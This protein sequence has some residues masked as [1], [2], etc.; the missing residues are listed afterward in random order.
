MSESC[1]ELF[2]FFAIEM[3]R[4]SFGPP[5]DSLGKV[6]ALIKAGLIDL[7]FLTGSPVVF[8]QHEPLDQREELILSN[9]QSQIQIDCLVNAVL[10]GPSYATEDSLLYNLLQRQYLSPFRNTGGIAVNQQVQ[11]LDANEQPVAGL[12]IIGRPTEGC[13]LGNDTLSRELHPQSDIWANRMIARAVRTQVP[14][15]RTGSLVD[16]VLTK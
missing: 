8:T 15:Q 13:V 11:A 6:L 3:E 5:A 1:W 16:Q 12:S 4:I 2:R 14:I 9:E 10:P 7:R